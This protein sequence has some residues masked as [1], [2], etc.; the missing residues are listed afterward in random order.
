[1]HH[2][3]GRSLLCSRWALINRFRRFCLPH[4]QPQMNVKNLGIVFGPTLLRS[5][6]AERDAMNSSATAAAV[7]FLVQHREEVFGPDESR[8]A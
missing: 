1:M 5:D 7:T 6:G 4:S 2:Q 3:I 8:D